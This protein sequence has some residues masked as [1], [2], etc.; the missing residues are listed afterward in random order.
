MNEERSDAPGTSARGGVD[1]LRMAHPGLARWAWIIAD[2][3]KMPYFALVALFVF[4]AYFTHDSR[5]RSRE[6]SGPL[7]PDSTVAAFTLAVGAPILGAIADAGGRRK[8]W[9]GLFSAIAVPGMIGLAFATPNMGEGVYWI[10]GS[11]LLAALGLEF[12]PIFMNSLLPT[13]A[14]PNEVGKVSGFG[15]AASNVLNLSSVLF[16]LLAWGWNSMPLFGLEMSAGEPQRAVGP[17]AALIFVAFSLPFYF[18]TPDNEESHSEG[19]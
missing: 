2:A 19:A 15:M 3:A 5:R 11:L 6:R 12:I 7:E 10:M 1:A 4:S 9:I 16:F 13:I 17:L 18:L 14:K 8:W